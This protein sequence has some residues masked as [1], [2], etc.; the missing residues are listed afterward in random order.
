MNSKI[1]AT[2]LKLLLIISIAFFSINLVSAKNIYEKKLPEK[3]RWECF[4][5]Y[6]SYNFPSD[7]AWRFKIK[8]NREDTVAVK[9]DYLVPIISYK[10]LW[11]KYKYSSLQLKNNTFLNDDNLKTSIKIDTKKIKKLF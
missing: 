6:W 5:F 9:W 4:E 2:W 8:V 3:F 1:S 10:K 7:N 11:E